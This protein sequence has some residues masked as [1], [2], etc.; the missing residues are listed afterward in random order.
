MQI[1]LS[2]EQNFS[3]SKNMQA[4]KRAKHQ[5]AMSKA[6]TG[7]PI[8]ICVSFGFVNQWIQWMLSAQDVWMR[9]RTVV[10]DE[11]LNE[12]R[13]GSKIL[14]AP[15]G[16]ISRVTFRSFAS[17]GAAGGKRRCA[18]VTTWAHREIVSVYLSKNHRSHD[19]SFGDQL[20]QCAC[21]STRGS[22]K[23]R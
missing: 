8:D 3:W 16:Q 9:L 22:K 17:P 15:W 14:C 10:F 1:F 11:N 18:H 7:L 4:P 2:L 13:K 5:Y 19:S 23:V 21:D 6:Q 12:K 20:R